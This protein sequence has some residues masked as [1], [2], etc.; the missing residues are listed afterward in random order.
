MKRKELLH[1]DHSVNQNIDPARNDAFGAALL[2]SLRRVEAT[3]W[4]VEEFER[5]LLPEVAALAAS[6]ATEQDIAQLQRYLEDYLSLH[7]RCV[8]AW[9][10]VPPGEIPAAETAELEERIRKLS[11]AIFEATHNWVL[12]LLAD[13]LVMLRGMRH[14]EGPEITAEG[15]IAG[16]REF[17][18]P[19]VDAVCRRDPAAARAAVANIQN[20]P[21]QAVAAMRATP[22]GTTIH[23][24]T[25]EADS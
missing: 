20:L 19:I 22:V 25:G 13:P 23:I 5:I 1:F 14:W 17:L 6:A 16:E 24:S 15:I 21:D 9:H 10:G 3:A 8:Q 4:D 18:V 12:I 11:V 2:L 7:A